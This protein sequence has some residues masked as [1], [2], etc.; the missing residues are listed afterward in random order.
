MFR[1]PR[2]IEHSTHQ[3]STAGLAATTSP[4]PPD[5]MAGEK[6]REQADYRSNNQLSSGSM[7]GRS[8]LDQNFVSSCT[9]LF[10][11][12]SLATCWREQSVCHWSV[13]CKHPARGGDGIALGVGCIRSVRPDPVHFPIVQVIVE[14][15]RI[16]HGPAEYERE[17]GLRPDLSPG[18]PVCQQ[19]MKPRPP[20]AIIIN[21][22]RSTP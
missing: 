12:P 10:C 16:Q 18:H 14:R 13:L 3:A 21:D 7:R 2:R 11:C 1:P 20:I 17:S 15:L 5:A 4:R 6:Q 8:S 19:G 9:V 22:S